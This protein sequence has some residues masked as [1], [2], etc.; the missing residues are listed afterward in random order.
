MD[1]TKYGSRSDAIFG[2][3]LIPLSHIKNQLNNVG[4]LQADLLAGLEGWMPAQAKNNYSR[5]FAFQCWA[6][7]LYYRR[8]PQNSSSAQLWK[9]TPWPTSRQLWL[10]LERPGLMS[11]TCL[12]PGLRCRPSSSGR[13]KRDGRL[14]IRTHLHRRSAFDISSISRAHRMIFH[15]CVHVCLVLVHSPGTG[16][17]TNRLD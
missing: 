7:S 10:L 14:T 8:Q 11:R 4:G 16:T 13:H 12:L 5:L 2:S 15:K 9:S 1:G 6:S 3:L 17:K